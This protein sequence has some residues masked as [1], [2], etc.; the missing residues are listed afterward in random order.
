MPHPT[1]TNDTIV[2]VSLLRLNGSRHGDRSA[3]SMLDSYEWLTLC[4][5]QGEIIGIGVG[6]EGSAAMHAGS[7]A[8]KLISL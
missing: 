3:S 8:F 1:N 5:V 2:I 4:R 6:W 7:R